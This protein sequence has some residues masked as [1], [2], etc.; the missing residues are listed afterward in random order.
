MFSTRK[1]KKQQKKQQSRLN[2]TLTDFST[3]NGTYVNAEENETLEPQNNN[4]HK[5]LRVLLTLQVKTRSE[6]IKLTTKLQEQSTIL[7]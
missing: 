3:G 4:Q 2:E 6:K 7:Y 1:K 5:D